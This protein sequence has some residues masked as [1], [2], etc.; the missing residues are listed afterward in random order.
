VSAPATSQPGGALPLTG[1]DL[2]RSWLAVSL[3][4]TGLG[5]VLVVMSRRRR[6]SPR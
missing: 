1:T 6:R 3:S 2:D 5:L 4:A